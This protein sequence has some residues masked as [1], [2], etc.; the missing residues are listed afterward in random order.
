MTRIATVV[1]T[2]AIAAV[3]LSGRA[4]SPSNATIEGGQTAPANG[5]GAPNAAAPTGQIGGGGNVGV[6][7][8]QTPGD[9]AAQQ[10]T[11][12]NSG[13]PVATTPSK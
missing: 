5:A 9:A 12:A 13:S 8:T 6:T 11:T 1:I 3:P 2:I 7:T 10:P 4:Q